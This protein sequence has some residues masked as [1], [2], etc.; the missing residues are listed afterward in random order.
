MTQQEFNFTHRKTIWHIRQTVWRWKKKGSYFDCYVPY[1]CKMMV[2][3]GVLKDK[4]VK[5][6]CK[7]LKDAIDSGLMENPGLSWDEMG[8]VD[9]HDV[10]VPFQM[11]CEDRFGIVS[12][13]NAPF[14][15]EKLDL[16]PMD[17]ELDELDQIEEQLIKLNKRKM[18]IRNR[19]IVAMQGYQTGESSHWVIV[20]KESQVLD[21]DK[22]ERLLGCRVALARKTQMALT[23]RRKENIT[24]VVHLV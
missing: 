10:V 4:E 20:A 2:I 15:E 23:R 3:L 5:K 6:V 7:L 11:F 14:N 1:F 24:G 22:A 21:K 13:P 9:L 17:Q 16:E 8:Q 18:D 19:L 12:A